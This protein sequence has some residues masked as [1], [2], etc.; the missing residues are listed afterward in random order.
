MVNRTIATQV[1]PSLLVG[2]LGPQSLDV[3]IERRGP[4]MIAAT[5]D[6]NTYLI[7]VRTEP[8]PR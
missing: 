3:K 8:R 4:G 1:D 6:G 2:E 5:F 7:T